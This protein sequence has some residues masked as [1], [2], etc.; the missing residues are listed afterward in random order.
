MRQL[1][2]AGGEPS[3][4]LAGA[5]LF[6]CDKC[7]EAVPPLRLHLVKIPARKKFNYEVLI[8][9]FETKEAAGKR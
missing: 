2:G 8:D 6:H 4:Q 7:D 9:V 1:L 5:E 3:E